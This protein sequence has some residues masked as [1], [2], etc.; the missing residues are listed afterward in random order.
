[1]KITQAHIEEAGIEPV[2]MESRY[3]DM[4]S[5]VYGTV[6]V[7][8]LEYDSADLLKDCDPTAYR[9][10]FAD[11]VSGEMGET[12]EEGPDGEYYDKGE[13]DAMVEALEEAEEDSE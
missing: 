4:L 5:E 13:W 10:G 12:V 9:C 8:G 2:D 6:N 3:H 11:Y 7:C 1:M